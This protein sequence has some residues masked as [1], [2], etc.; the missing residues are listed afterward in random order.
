MAVS[1]KRFDILTGETNLPSS[2]FGAGKVTNLINTAEN[3]LKEAGAGIKSLL[4]TALSGVIGDTHSSA[5]DSISSV[6]REIKSASGTLIDYTKLNS[7]SVSKVVSTVT[8]TDQK[9]AKTM[10]SILQQCGKGSSYSYS[11]KPYDISASCSGNKTSLGSSGTA[12]GCGVTNYSNLLN[13]LT[14]GGYNNI[15]KDIA[16]ALRAFM[17]LAG[18]GYNL[19][20]CNVFSGL[21]DSSLFSNLG[22][23]STE[24]AKA[25]G[26]LLGTLGQAG[27]VNGWVDVAKSSTGYAVKL[28]NPDAVSDLLCG[29]SLSST[30]RESDYVNYMTSTRAGMELYDANWLQS[31]ETGSLSSSSLYGVST[32]YKD[33][34]ESWLCNRDYGETDLDTIEATDDTYYTSAVVSNNYSLDSDGMDWI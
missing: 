16:S 31:M 28:V 14:G 7:D 20:L 1:E 11:G 2:S 12:S 4:S 32:D 18:Y 33:V 10:M 23:G 6:S 13:Q 27:N 34:S 30:T 5:K 9:N 29:F 3:E 26:S 25:A 15:Y 21:S 17:S 19:G 24:Y 8:G 22:L